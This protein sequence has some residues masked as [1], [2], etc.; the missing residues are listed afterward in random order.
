MNRTLLLVKDKT[1]LAKIKMDEA[2]EVMEFSTTIDSDYDKAQVLARAIDIKHQSNKLMREAEL[3]YNIAQELKHGQEALTDQANNI[4]NYMDKF[5]L[6][7]DP[8]DKEAYLDTV[9]QGVPMAESM[10]KSSKKRH[11]LENYERI[12]KEWSK[13]IKGLTRTAFERLDSLRNLYEI[14]GRKL[15]SLDGTLERE[16]KK[17]KKAEIQEEID[18]KKAE[19]HEL[20][21]LLAKT[22][23]EAQRYDTEYNGLV[24]QVAMISDLIN[25][26]EIT[27][28]PKDENLI[29]KIEM[30][31]LQK[32]IE[33]N[34]KKSAERVSN[35][36]NSKTKKI[37]EE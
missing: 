5:S 13:D 6:S 17:G 12:K 20:G 22:E 35:E 37:E 19:R 23:N 7:E 16:T 3:A 14:A 21:E 2:N 36:I 18:R 28:V 24:K 11:G 27:P 9:L 30:S 29:A 10:I 4:L 31:L 34:K 26:I 33:E 32:A 15:V 8:R 25:D 1:E